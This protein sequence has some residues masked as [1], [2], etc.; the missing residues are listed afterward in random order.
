MEFRFKE[1]P[2]NIQANMIRERIKEL[3]AADET[4]REMVNSFNDQ[5]EHLLIYPTATIRN[6]RRD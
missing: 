1:L 4:C 6:F 5:F 3:V 2:Q